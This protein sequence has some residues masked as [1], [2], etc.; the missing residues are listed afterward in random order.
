M[1]RICT[2]TG[3]AGETAL[4]GGKRVSKDDLRVRAY[5]TVDELN[6]VVGVA[7]GGRAA[8]RAHRRP[9]GRAADRPARRPRAGQSRG[10][11]VR[12]PALRSALRARPR[13]QPGRRPSGR[14]LEAGPVGRP[15]RGVTCAPGRADAVWPASG[16]ASA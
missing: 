4:F 1:T 6:A 16:R 3:D 8:P 7:R 14:G 2:R 9:E 11:Q 5:G 10:P 12:E 15:G 13:G